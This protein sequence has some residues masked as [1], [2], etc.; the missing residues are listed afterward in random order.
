MQYKVT[1]ETRLRGAIGIFE[2][3][4][5]I[6]NARTTEHAYMRAMDLL[7]DAGYETGFSLA[8]EEMTGAPLAADGVVNA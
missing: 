6:V 4:F 1:F 2:P 7:H 3:R 5:C 8:A